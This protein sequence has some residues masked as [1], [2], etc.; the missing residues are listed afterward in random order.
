MT[1]TAPAAPRVARPPTGRPLLLFD[2][3]CEFCR[4]WI[5]RWREAA[6]GRLDLE[7]AQTAASRFPEISSAEFNRAVQLIDTQGQVFSAAEAIF[8]ARAGATGRN[9]LLT[10][11]ERLPGFAAAAETLYRFVAGHRPIFSLLTRLLWG[12]EVRRPS[13][14]TS[15]WI[16]LRLLG[17]VHL[18]AFLSFWT[19]LGG[20]VGPQ[21]ILPAQPYF[22]AVGASLGVSRLWQLP[23]LCWWFGGGWFLQVLCGAGVAL[24]LA[25]IAGCA[26]ALC[27]LGLW[28]AYLSL[29]AAGQIFMNYQWDALLLETTLL[30]I[31]VTPWSAWTWSRRADPPRPA[32]WLLWWLLFRLMLLSGAVK[33]LSGDPA[34]RHLTALKY[35]FETQPLPTWLGWYAHQLP[36]WIKSTACAGMFAIELGAPFLLLLP[37]RARQGGALLQISLQA[38]IALTGNYTFFNLLTAALCLLF[39]DDACWRNLARRLGLRH[40]TGATARCSFPR[41]CPRWLLR[42]AAGAIFSLTA[43]VTLGTLFPRM[44]W[45]RGLLAV[46]EAVAPF[47]SFNS[48]GLFAVMTRERPEI[49]IE[50]SDDGRIWLPYT[51]KAKPG[52]PQRRPG[53]VAPHQPRLDWQLWFAALESPAENP[54]VTNL[55]ERLLEGS[56]DVLALFASN[57]FPRRPPRRI[58]AVLYDYRFTS[59]RQ[60][61]ATGNWWDRTPVDYYVPPVSLR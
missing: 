53:F 14:G 43:L 28:T 7:P 25:L 61:A 13:F 16:F 21:G 29:C 26:P 39:F 31:F 2:G 36:G 6:G 35:H 20:L 33:L 5:E 59:R 48:Y 27:L 11:Y 8:R 40:S 18:I 24:S 19:Q 58:R 45:P 34:W 46:Q 55:C 22:D 41:W 1:E 60:R 44:T 42:P 47:R 57:P 23:T 12:A 38:L 3:E 10:A 56:P 49:I 9:G 51:F 52:D 50:G 37:R 54:W 15:T 30:A 17:A 32:R 4:L